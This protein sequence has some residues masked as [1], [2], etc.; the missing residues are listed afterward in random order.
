MNFAEPPGEGTPSILA[1]VVD[2]CVSDFSGKYCPI[3][4]GGAC[5]GWTLMYEGESECCLTDEE[6][7]GDIGEWVRAL[8]GGDQIGGK[9]AALIRGNRGWEKIV[10]RRVMA[11]LRKWAP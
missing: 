4:E 10:A 6:V 11:E 7:A 9:I 8:E 5:H 2:Q 1:I 3:E